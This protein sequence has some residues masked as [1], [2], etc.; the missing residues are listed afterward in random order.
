[1]ENVV[2]WEKPLCLSL[3]LIFFAKTSSHEFQVD[4]RGWLS[5]IYDLNIKSIG[6]AM[7]CSKF[8][9]A[10]KISPHF[11]QLKQIVCYKCEIHK[12]SNPVSES[13]RP[14]LGRLIHQRVR[15]K[16]HRRYTILILSLLRRY[17]QTHLVWVLRNDWLTSLSQHNSCTLLYCTLSTGNILTMQLGLFSLTPVPPY[18]SARLMC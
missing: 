13:H 6:P 1:M 17:S 8:V 7:S 2:S 14:V 5:K 15:Y 18:H 9:L 12:R 16:K 3:G 11:F 10:A 4:T